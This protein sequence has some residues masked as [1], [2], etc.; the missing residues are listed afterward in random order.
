MPPWPPTSFVETVTVN[1]APRS[2]REQG[3]IAKTPAQF[4]S[5]IGIG[6][7]VTDTRRSALLG[8][9]PEA[10]SRIENESATRSHVRWQLILMRYGLHGPCPIRAAATHELPG[11]RVRM[12]NDRQG[13]E[14]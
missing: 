7:G 5:K 8:A 2:S 13:I 3:N 6:S 1:L 4:D 10:R 9:Q 14:R 11:S 12:P